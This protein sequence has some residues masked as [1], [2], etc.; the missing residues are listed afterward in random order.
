M[1]KHLPILL[2]LV[3]AATWAG[4]GKISLENY[5]EQVKSQNPEAQSNLATMIAFETKRDQELG[6]TPELYTQYS[7]LDDKKQTAQPIFMGDRTRVTDLKFGVRSQTN[8]GLGADLYF[9]TTRTN[10]NG[11][12]PNFFPVNDWQEAK[13]VLELKQNLWRN[14]FGEATRGERD[15][16]AAE[17]RTGYLKAKFAL[18]TILLNAENTY[19]SVVTYNQIVKL[20][21]ENV[22]R[23]RR[24]RDL[25]LRR[26]QMRLFDDVDAMQAEA[27]LQSRELELE[28]SVNERAL[29]IRK[30]NT[31]RGQ[32]VDSALELQELAPNQ[33]EAMV[34]Q[35]FSGKFSREDFEM[36]REQ[37]KMLKA[38]STAGASRIQP[39]LDLVAS[40][41]SN[42]RNG[43]ASVAYQDLTDGRHPSWQAGI[44]FSIPL[45]FGLIRD[46]NRSFDRMNVA[47]ASQTTQANYQESR[48]WDDVVKQRTEAQGRYERG[49]KLENL[50]TELVVKER[51][52]LMN[53]RATTFEALTFEQ[54]LALAQI[55]RVRA[56]L[57]LVQ[58]NNVLK[59][60][61][62]KT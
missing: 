40:M 34:K 60:F 3:G 15:A 57:E 17:N 47:A 35:K 5:L 26:A 12:D 18:R 21:E 22:D 52:R 23:A 36:I 31:L 39:Q 42:G 41:A 27:S 2:F 48:Y 10:L 61:S 8:Y 14:G 32:D 55:Q 20:Q 19:W 58:I 25:M 38:Q 37:A 59:T 29:L 49:V 62:E 50:Q 54:N 30:F 13:A 43:D 9:D 1:I 4:E 16:K 24:L 53:G 56:Q 45:D 51:A 6:T 11:V 46:L 7:M 33:I 44:Q 28:S